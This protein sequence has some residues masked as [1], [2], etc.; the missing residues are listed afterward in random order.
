MLLSSLSP[1]PLDNNSASQTRYV[2]E[3]RTELLGPRSLPL[4]SPDRLGPAAFSSPAMSALDA[5]DVRR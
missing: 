5:V 4:P 1:L 2:F 3:Q